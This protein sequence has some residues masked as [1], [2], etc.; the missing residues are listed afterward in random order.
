MISCAVQAIHGRCLQRHV[1]H[2]FCILYIS[3]GLRKDLPELSHFEWTV[4]SHFGWT[5]DDSCRNLLQQQQSLRSCTHTCTLCTRTIRINDS[6]NVHMSWGQSDVVCI[7]PWGP[8]SKAD[9]TAGTHAPRPMLIHFPLC[10]STDSRQASNADVR[11][12]AVKLRTHSKTGV[13]ISPVNTMIPGKVMCSSETLT[14]FSDKYKSQ[15]AQCLL[16]S[17]PC[18]FIFSHKTHFRVWTKVDSVW[19]RRFFLSEKRTLLARPNGLL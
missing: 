15:T 1:R 10:Y 19:E 18:I 14:H 8:T 11:T 6:G 17:H 7:I 16:N 5:F 4:P 12:H 9:T 13:A 3:F 2:C